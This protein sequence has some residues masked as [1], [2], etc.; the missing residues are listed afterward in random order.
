MGLVSFISLYGSQLQSPK[1]QESDAI[2]GNDSLAGFWRIGPFRTWWKLTLLRDAGVQGNRLQS[3]R[4]DTLDWI[5]KRILHDSPEKS[6]CISAKGKSKHFFFGGRCRTSK[7]QIKKSTK[8][9]PGS[10]SLCLPRTWDALIH[11]SHFR[12][13][14][15]KCCFYLAK[16]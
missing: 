9:R 6:E 5:I 8:P 12:S 1:S 7:I 13:R 3:T 2:H 11:C 16:E 4:Q 14:R 10:F 15:G